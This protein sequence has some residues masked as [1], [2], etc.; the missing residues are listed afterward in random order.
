MVGTVVE[1]MVVGVMVV[2][3]EMEEEGAKAEEKAEE[4]MQW[5][6]RGSPTQSGHRTSHHSNFQLRHLAG[7]GNLDLDN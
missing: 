1:V 2:G 6:H 7:K 4:E 3:E 5:Y